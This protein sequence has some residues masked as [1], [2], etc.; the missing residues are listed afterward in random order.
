MEK[1]AS[2]YF[3]AFWVRGKM[4]AAE[5]PKQNAAG[6]ISPAACELWLGELSC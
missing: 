1:K 4:K 6:E 2:K 3:D 5:M